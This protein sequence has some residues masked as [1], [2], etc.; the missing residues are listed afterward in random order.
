MPVHFHSGPA[1]MEQFFGPLPPSE[2][3]KVP[4][5]AVGAYVRC[6]VGIV[7]AVPADEGDAAPSFDEP[8]EYPSSEP[9]FP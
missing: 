3:G 7:E 5:G 9:P 2:D 1:P 6:G 8:G 4:P